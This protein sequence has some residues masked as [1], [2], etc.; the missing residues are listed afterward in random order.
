MDVFAF[1]VAVA[2]HI[3]VIKLSGEADLAAADMMEGVGSATA[4]DPSIREVIVD[5]ADMTFCDSTMLGLL[6]GWRNLSDQAGS[7]F[8]LR[9]VPERMMTLLRITALDK[10]LLDVDPADEVTA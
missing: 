10:L 7:T 1:E 9:D 8:T 6:V 3:A 5:C 4:G 2:D